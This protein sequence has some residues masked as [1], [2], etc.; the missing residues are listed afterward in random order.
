MDFFEDIAFPWVEG[1]EGGFT[2]DPRDPGNWTGGYV[3]GGTLKGTKYGVSAAAYPTLDIENLTMQDAARIA[4]PKYW[5][6]AHCDDM[7]QAVAL[8]VYDFAYNAGVHESVKVLQRTL[9]IQQDGF[10]GHETHD[11]L[12]SQDP[13]AVVSNFTQQRINAYMQMR[14]WNV[15]GHGWRDRSLATE[16]KAYQL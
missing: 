16:Q 1:I 11:A 14:G 15:Y 12:W 10:Y 2:K 4:R 6:A 5:D 13:R 7:P 9:G 3:G 8:C